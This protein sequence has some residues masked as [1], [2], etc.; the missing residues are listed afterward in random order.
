MLWTPEKHYLDDPFET[1]AQLEAAIAAVSATLFGPNRV[2]LDVKKRIGAKGKTK[3]IPDGYLID[4]TSKREPRLFV[5]ENELASHDP[6]NHVAVQ[7]LEFSIS[8]E[9]S[10]YKVKGILRE[11]LAQNKTAR[12]VCEDYAA[13]NGFENL[14]FL[15]E[16]LLQRDDAFSALVIIDE[17]DDELE[18]LLLKRLKFPVEVLTLQRFKTAAGKIAYEFDPFLADVTVPVTE[19]KGKAGKWQSA[20]DPS[21]LD[22]IVVPAQE[23]GFNATFLGE[24]RW[25]QIRI[26]SSMIPR[27]KYIAAYQVAPV[28]AIT[29]VAPVESIK[30]WKNTSGYVVNMS[31][32]AKKVGPIRLVPKS[33]VVKALRSPR[34]SAY[35]RLKNAK[36]LDEAF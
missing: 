8:F 7:L 35:T 4:L 34:Y 25:H 13:Q 5:V 20:V 31:K 6:L 27:I 26:H 22:T 10:A 36:T 2:Y 21:D 29:H 23:E 32:A 12:R 11:A 17:L 16:S 19:A 30:L 9:A 3:N 14:D 15:L 1:E 33:G 18:T 24:D 28:S